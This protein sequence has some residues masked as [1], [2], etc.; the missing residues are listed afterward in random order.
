MKKFMVIA[1]A[2]GLLILSGCALFESR[3]QAK[4]CEYRIISNRV[5]GRISG[6]QLIVTVP[7]EARNP[8]NEQNAVIDRMRLTLYVGDQK[9][10]QGE[11]PSKVVIPAGRNPE[12][13]TARFT[14]TGQGLLTVLNA[15][16]AK[17]ISYKVTGT[18]FVTVTFPGNIT[19]EQSFEITILEDSW[20]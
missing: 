19:R 3:M 7:I 14:V 17:N 13:F 4:N 12:E 16:R 1:A 10:L 20:R 11:V 15:I 5:S 2:I 18:V 6:S 9:S 8:H